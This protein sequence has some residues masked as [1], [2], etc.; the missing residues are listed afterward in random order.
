VLVQ[1]EHLDILPQC[2][3]QL[4]NLEGDWPTIEQESVENVICDVAGHNIA[5]VMYTS[6]ST[7]KPKGVLVL[8]RGVCNYLLWRRVYFPLVET[9]RVLQKTSFSFVDS[10]WELFEPLMMGA[11]LI[12]AE[13]DR[14]QDPAYLVKFII[15]QKI[16]AADFIPSLLTLFLEEPNV[17]SC[18]TL[19]RV[20]TGSETVT[21]ELQANFFLAA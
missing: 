18:I 6:G 3:A 13:P 10:V 2:E 16:T 1:N 9:D 17:E 4:I 8:H 19:R 14:H 7:G 20:T 11:R 21:P 15:D 5:Y 12:M